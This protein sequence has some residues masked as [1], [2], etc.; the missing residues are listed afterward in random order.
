MKMLNKQAYTS[1]ET[2]EFE[3]LFESNFLA[4]VNGGDKPV[5]DSEEGDTEGWGWN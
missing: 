1:P 2:K 4:T 3:F 5:D